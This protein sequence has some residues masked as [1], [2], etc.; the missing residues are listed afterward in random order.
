[1]AGCTGTDLAVEDP[2]TLG[3]RP[4]VGVEE[5]APF[6][7]LLRAR[8]ALLGRADVEATVLAFAFSLRLALRAVLWPRATPNLRVASASGVFLTAFSPPWLLVGRDW[9]KIRAESMLQA[10][11]VHFAPQLVKS[12]QSRRASAALHDDS[13]VGAVH[14]EVQSP[15]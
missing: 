6:S 12:H 8:A 10:V 11:L 15:G 7:L 5:V 4:A 3:R 14:Y 1:M 9:P 2:S 13:N